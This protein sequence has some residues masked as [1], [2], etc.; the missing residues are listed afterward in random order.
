MDWLIQ[1]N[2]LSNAV[3]HKSKKTVVAVVAVFAAVAFVVDVYVGSVFAS[4]C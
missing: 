3:L 4:V 1:K 2:M